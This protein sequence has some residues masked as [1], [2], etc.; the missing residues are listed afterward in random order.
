MIRNPLYSIH[1]SVLRSQGE[2]GCAGDAEA[3][4]FCR[5]IAEY[6]VQE[7]GIRRREAV[8]RVNE[9]WANPEHRNWIVGDDIAYHETAGYWAKNIYYGPD[10]RWQTPKGQQPTPVPFNEDP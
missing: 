10:W 1:H 7:F 2:F 9:A 8:G 3:L 5:E 4:R 6:M